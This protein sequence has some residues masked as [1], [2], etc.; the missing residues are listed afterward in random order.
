[1][2]LEAG[3]SNIMLVCG[4]TSQK[5]NVDMLFRNSIGVEFLASQR[6]LY[7]LRVLGQISW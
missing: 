1:M 3:G 2:Q 6:T 5:A 7:V 4:V